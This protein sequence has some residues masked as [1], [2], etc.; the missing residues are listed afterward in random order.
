MARQWKDQKKI[1]LYQILTKYSWL[2]IFPKVACETIQ[3]EN[4]ECLHLFSAILVT[5]QHFKHY[6]FTFLKF[7]NKKFRWILCGKNYTQISLKIYLTFLCSIRKKM[8][9]NRVFRQIFIE[10]FI[11]VRAFF[12]FGFFYCS[13]QR[14]KRTTS[15]SSRNL[16]HGRTISMEAFQKITETFS[17][18]FNCLYLEINHWNLKKV[19]NLS[20]F[21]S[22]NEN[23]S[24]EAR[25]SNEADQQFWCSKV[26]GFVI[27][28]LIKWK[29]SKKNVCSTSQKIYIWGSSTTHY[30]DLVFKQ[31]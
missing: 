25:L 5:F 27:S 3:L 20:T 7:S 31:F 9:K 22:V 26:W 17:K 10:T 13:L 29:Y 21:L 2:I 1:T 15:L 6:F 4:A 24:S 14:S 8:H 19:V 11:K 12:L 16:T 30:E 23:W 28:R 18:S